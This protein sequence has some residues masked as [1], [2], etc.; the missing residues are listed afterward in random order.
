MVSVSCTF[1]KDEVETAYCESKTKCSKVFKSKVGHGK[2]FRKWFRI[3]FEVKRKCSEL[4]KKSFS[5]FLKIFEW[6][7]WN[8]FLESNTRHS[9]NYLL[10]KLVIEA[11]YKIVFK[12]HWGQIQIIW[13]FEKSIF[14]LFFLLQF[15]E[16]RRRNCFLWKRGEALKAI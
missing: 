5:R 10:F 8:H 13:F 6:Q 7:S 4:L 3:Y 15:L 12:L 11:F 9:K 1:L 2:H 14:H 16:W